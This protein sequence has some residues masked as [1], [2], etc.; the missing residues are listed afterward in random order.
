MVQDKGEI[1]LEIRDDGVGFDPDRIPEDRFGV[2][3]IIERA[4]LFGGEAKFKSEAGRG[5]LL[6]VRLPLDV[7]EAA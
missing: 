2:R 3:G 1:I 5:T 6:T 4:R 7:M